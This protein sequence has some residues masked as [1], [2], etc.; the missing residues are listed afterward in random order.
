MRCIYYFAIAF[1]INT[2]NAVAQ[3]DVYYGERDLQLFSNDLFLDKAGDL[4]PSQFISDSLM[5]SYDGRLYLLFAHRL[6]LFS[7]TLNAYG[8]IQLG[9]FNSLYQNLQQEILNEKQ[10]NWKADPSKD[11]SIYFLIHGFRK[12]FKESNRDYSSSKDFL[13]MKNALHLQNKSVVTIYW[14]ATYDCCFSSNVKKNKELFQ[15]FV[16]AQERTPFIAKRLASILNQV[17][18]ANIYLVSHSL[19]AKIWM[20]TFPMLEYVSKYYKVLLVAPAIS[21]NELIHSIQKKSV[22]HLSIGIVYNRHDFVLK[23]K[24]PYIGWFGPGVKKYGT[25]S[26]GCNKQNAQN[27][28]KWYQEQYPYNLTFTFFDY[29]W[30][31]K[32]HHVRNYF[33]ESHMLD[34]RQFIHSDF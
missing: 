30:V 32:G 31:G 19:G 5:Q 6:D 4:Y 23:K 3:N 10:N 22:D 8:L 21:A 1:I 2:S 18:V 11:S 28:L 7:K 24:D 12:P 15:L 13:L 9:T 16:E 17:N 27:K 25:T 34:L 33:V 26:L 14:D 29:K 20:E